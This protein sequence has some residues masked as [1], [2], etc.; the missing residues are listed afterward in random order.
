MSELVST[1]IRSTVG[2]LG[3]SHLA[4]AINEYIRRTDEG[5]MG[6]LDP[7]RTVVSLTTAARAACTP[8]WPGSL[9]SAAIA[10]RRCRSFT[11]GRNAPNRQS[12]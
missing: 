5:K 11:C 1:R 10:R 4:E 6:Y 8:P 3:L 9:A 12:G 2:K 7:Q